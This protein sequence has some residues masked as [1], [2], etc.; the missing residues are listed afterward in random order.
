MARYRVTRTG[1]ESSWQ[2]GQHPHIAMLCLENGQSV[3][4]ARAIAEITAGTNTYY[5]DAG[6]QTATVEVA[7]RCSRCVAPYLRTD[8]DTTTV[9]NL[10]SLPDC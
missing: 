8:R 4:K 3:P 9:D 7:A 2:G 5:T 6:G 10:L 1:K